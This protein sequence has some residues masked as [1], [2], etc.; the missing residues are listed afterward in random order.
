MSPPDDVS[1]NEAI[2]RRCTWVYASMRVSC[3]TV[4]ARFR[5]VTRAMYSVIDSASHT[6]TVITAR[7]VSCWN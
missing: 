4:C 5:H 1:S 3:S 6:K 2:S 7:T